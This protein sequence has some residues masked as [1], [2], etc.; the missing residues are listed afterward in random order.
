[1]YRSEFA[2]RS[3]HQLWPRTFLETAAF[4][5]VGG[6]SRNV[7]EDLPDWSESL[8]IVPRAVSSTSRANR[9]A[10]LRTS[11]YR[12]SETEIDKAMRYVPG[13]C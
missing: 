10:F 1:M 9:R 4:R 12:P 6:P 8:A 5:V 3:V 7:A 11:V 13:R 2:I